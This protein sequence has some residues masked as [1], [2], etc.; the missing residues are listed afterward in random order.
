MPVSHVSFHLLG[1][2]NKIVDDNGQIRSTSSGQVSVNV[3]TVNSRSLS[4]AVASV[5]AYRVFRF[6]RGAF[7]RVGFLFTRVALIFT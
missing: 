7:S 1:A 5:Y 6:A 4:S 2:T 3:R